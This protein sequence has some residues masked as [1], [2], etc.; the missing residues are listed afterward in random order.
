MAVKS[1]SK[2]K[3]AGEAE[4]QLMVDEVQLM[5]RVRGHANVVELAEW[6]EDAAHF[7]MVLEVC[8]GGELMERI[9]KEDHFS[10]KAAAAL[11]QQMA[12]A[13]QWCH[14]RLVCHRDLKP[15]NFLFA[16]RARGAALKLTDFGLAC[17]VESAGAL[18][19]D[20]CGSA[21]YIAPEVFRGAY[22]MAADVFSLGVNLYL[23]LSGSVPF[24][25]RCRTEEAIYRAL[26]SEVLH[27]D[28]SWARSTPAVRELLS[29]LLD[30]DPAKRYTLEQVL[31]HPWVTG[32]AASDE[33][34]DRSVLTSLMDFTARNKFKKEARVLLA[35]PTAAESRSRRSLSAK[36]CRPTHPPPLTAPHPHPPTHALPPA[37]CGSW[38]RPSRPPRWRPC[39]PS[40]CGSTRTT[41]ASSPSPSSAPRWRASASTARARA[42]R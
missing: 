12:A 32:E 8:E 23:M 24:G 13:V 17:A 30:K 39:A 5:H 9:V 18:I 22:T 31:S 40:S 2:L 1:I 3:F 28:A 7:H 27:F 42:R 36:G 20:A 34:I 11:F 41:R 26:Q 33:R 10:E 21:Y 25:A 35:A 6:S 16:S 37:A 29:G 38:P 4:R 15:E 19:E 14:S